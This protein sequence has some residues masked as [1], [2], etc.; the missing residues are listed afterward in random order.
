MSHS[1]R[2]PSNG[3]QKAP[4]HVHLS[5]PCR[6]QQSRASC[7]VFAIGW[8]R[9]GNFQ[10]P[11]PKD[12]RK[13]PSHPWFPTCL[14]LQGRAKLSV[15]LN[16]HYF[17]YFSS[18]WIHRID[19]HASKSSK[20]GEVRKVAVWQKGREHGRL[21]AQNHHDSLAVSLQAKRCVASMYKMCSIMPYLLLQLF[22]LIASAGLV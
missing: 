17:S 11:I 19:L 13:Q 9:I 1:I 22:N 3:L 10:A 14:A 7:T 15:V 6:R 4:Q 18:F 20:S 2:T 16:F 5:R 8:T 12:R 21:V